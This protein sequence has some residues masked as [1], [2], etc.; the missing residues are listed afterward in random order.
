MDIYY[1]ENQQ[2]V[3]SLSI[4]TIK[5]KLVHIQNLNILLLFRTAQ[6][7]LFQTRGVKLVNPAF[8]I[9]KLFNTHEL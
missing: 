4:M 3:T 6:D 9:L 8:P 5:S 7:F 1:T 2:Y